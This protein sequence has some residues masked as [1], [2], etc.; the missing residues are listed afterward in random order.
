MS[1][2]TEEF[3]HHGFCKVRE[4]IPRNLIDPHR[5]FL[6][7]SH[8]L[9][10][11]GHDVH[12]NYY[13]CPPKH[14]VQWANTWS[15]E[16]SETQI[17][18]VCNK[19][20]TPQIALLLDDP[21]LYHS[22]VVT[23]YPNYQTVRPHIDT[24]YR[25]E[26]FADEDA[27]LGVQCLLPLTENFG[28]RTGGTAFVPGSHNTKWNIKDCYNGKHDDYFTENCVTTQVNYGEMLIWHPRVLHSATPNHGVEKR[29]ALLMLYVERHIHDE[30]R[31]IENII[32]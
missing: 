28:P 27:F 19:F 1:F 24:P 12:G 20:Y 32:S 17:V 13:S 16:L 30:L 15:Q 2:N 18:H 5:T 25:H 26:S 11:R 23:T 3:W 14:K 10:D 21:V 22:D 7:S 4:N 9:I 29:P 8:I 31:V 6:N